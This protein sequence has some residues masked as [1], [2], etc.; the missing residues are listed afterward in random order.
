MDT[1][2]LDSMKVYSRL[3]KGVILG[4]SRDHTCIIDL[5][6]RT[7][8]AEYEGYLDIANNFGLY[9]V[10]L[11]K[12][13]TGNSWTI[14][15]VPLLYDD[16][17]ASIKDVLDSIGISSSPH[18]SYYIKEKEIDGALEYEINSF[19][20]INHIVTLRGDKGDQAMCGITNNERYF[21]YSSEGYLSIYDLK[22]KKELKPQHK[23]N[24]ANKGKLTL[25]NSVLFL[26]GNTY[27]IIDL[28]SGEMLVSIP[29]LQMDNQQVSF[30]PDEKW[31]L[32]GQYLVNIKDRQIISNSI[33]YGYNRSLSNEHI[34]YMNKCFALPRKK[35][36]VKQITSIL[37]DGL[38]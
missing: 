10:T 37:E 29:E 38:K 9:S 28:A 33:P 30:S 16:S 20:T 32:A 13:Y 36:L 12:G 2:V 24:A 8:I 7:T 26:P 18:G 14:A 17:S 6:S 19:P 23:I 4:Q 25:A 15:H 5:R 21:I 35:E 22:K 3:S 27:R 34:V 1:D 11:R 31:M